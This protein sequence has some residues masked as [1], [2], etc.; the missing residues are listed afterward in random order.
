MDWPLS[1]LGEEGDTVTVR[2]E[3][4]VKFADWEVSCT[5]VV[6]LSVTVAQ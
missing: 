1:I 5:G 6:G 2:A 4:T 3:F